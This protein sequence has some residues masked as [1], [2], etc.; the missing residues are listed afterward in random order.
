MKR[1]LSIT[2]SCLAAAAAAIVPAVI[3]LA[4]NPSSSHQLP[5]R[6][7][8]NARTATI[9]AV[10]HQRTTDDFDMAD[11]ARDPDRN[12]R[13]ADVDRERTGQSSDVER[14]ED[15]AGVDRDRDRG[16]ELAES[17]HDG[18]RGDDNGGTHDAQEHSE[19]NG[20]DGH[21]IGHER[22]RSEGGQDDSGE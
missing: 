11:S 17:R 5:V 1:I 12:H 15:H 21:S 7:P 3:G 9:V 18:E 8:H 10:A 6:V 4:G 13:T 14:H 16:H 22:D 20:D 19:R 2:V